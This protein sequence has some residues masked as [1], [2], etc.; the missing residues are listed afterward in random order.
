MGKI[1]ATMHTARVKHVWT[2]AMT[3]DMRRRIA[4]QG[5]DALKAATLELWES[6]S[7]TGH[8]VTDPHTVVWTRNASPAPALKGVSWSVLA[9][10]LR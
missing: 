1:S 6:D 7:F 9:T 4:R 2:N 5:A 10:A 3:P 8:G